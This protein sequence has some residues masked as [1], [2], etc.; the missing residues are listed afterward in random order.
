MNPGYLQKLLFFDSE[1]PFKIRTRVRNKAQNNFET[2]SSG[3]FFQSIL[4][5]NAFF[6]LFLLKLSIRI[7]PI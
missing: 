6:K 5:F 4:I 7:W 3:Q 2:E 1:V